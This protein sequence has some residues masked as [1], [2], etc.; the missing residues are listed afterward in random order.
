MSWYRT[1]TVTV[2]NGNATVVGSGT[3]WSGTV[4]PGWVFLGPDGITYE[5]ES[6]SS[7][8]S[9]TLATNY[10]GSTLVGASYATYPTQG[11]TRA[12]TTSVAELISSYTALTD[13]ITTD[14]AGALV[15][16]DTDYEG[17]WPDVTAATRIHRA[18]GRMFIGDAA[19]ATGNR[20]GTQGGKVP[21]GTEGANW[22][23]RDGQFVSF[24][25]Q[26]NMAVVGF[27]RSED[28]DPTENTSS[29]GVSGFAIGNN[30]TKAVWG[31]Y[32]DVQFEAGTYGYGLELAVKNKEG[33][34]R[35]T[36]PYFA[37]TGT[38]G[39]WLPAGG[40]ATY[41]GA[42]THPSNTAILIGSN[43]STWNRGI[44]F[45]EDGLTRSSGFATAMHLAEKHRIVWATNGNHE[46]F[47]IRSD[48][49]SA[50]SDVS[51]TASNS[52]ITLGGV[53]GATML[54]VSHASSGVN[55][56][57]FSNAAA[58]NYPTWRSA[59][60]DT[61][62]GWFYVAKGTAPHRFCAQNSVSY[63]E[64]RV[65]GINAAP[66][67]YLHAYGTDSGAGYAVL[68][69]GGTDSTVDVWLKPK[70]VN[71]RVRLGPYAS[72]SDVAIT[73]TMEVRDTS[74]VLRLVA[75]VG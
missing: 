53:G 20:T 21:T 43:S 65:G 29:I 59:G 63:E 13:S 73:G 22:A 68:S 42:P 48:V 49:D 35:T 17:M 36:T 60:A 44:V 1:G 26:G 24:A 46:G 25:Q 16:G 28:V 9:I 6:V 4:D 50:S 2:T 11:L 34:N 47:A 62:I 37:T 66:V 54:R 38:Y 72:S 8:T 40:D 52:S 64:F 71:G 15:V 31:L 10:A 51:L 61:D 30:A 56:G 75:I 41:G 33:V 69:A 70:G 58:G 57:T 23:I 32:G 19:D 5:V 39:I 14:D 45:L 3:A 18:W 74:G 67:N 7:D 12:L 55:Y 27:S